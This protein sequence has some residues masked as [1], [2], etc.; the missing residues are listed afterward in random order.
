VSAEV[1][2]ALIAFVA[3]ILGGLMQAAFSYL[4]SGRQFVRD[5][6][7]RDYNVFVEA[8]AGMSQATGEDHR[9]EFI[10]KMIEAKSRIILKSSPSVLDALEKYSR[11]D[12]L[13]S[14][15]SY[16]AF[17]NLLEAMR[18]DI[19]GKSVEQFTRKVKN[20]LFEGRKA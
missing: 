8:I 10:A 17:A 19:G 12:V 15:D 1:S 4:Q 9:K 11:H 13:S 6:R 5:S 18:A 14:E 20:I 16:R 2:A 7:H 3:A